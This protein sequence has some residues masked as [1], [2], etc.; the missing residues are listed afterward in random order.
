M[1]KIYFA[2]AGAALVLA[3]TPALASQLIA[4][5]FKNRGGCSWWMA[6][7][8]GQDTQTWQKSFS[9][10]QINGLWWVVYG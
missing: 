7:E 6:N 10:E 9:C 5:P 2:L 3:A 1:K 8:S 4:G